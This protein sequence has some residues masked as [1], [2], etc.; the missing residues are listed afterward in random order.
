MNNYMAPYIALEGNIGSG[1]STLLRT[2]ASR[3]SDGTVHV[4]QE[5]VDEWESSKLLQAFYMDPLKNAAYFQMYVHT[6]RVRQVIQSSSTN[7]KFMVAERS[8]LSS[9]D[10]FGQEM[11]DM[12]YMGD[13]AWTAYTAVADL[14]NDL[15]HS[16]GNAVNPAGVIYLRC[17][18]EVCM[19]RVIKRS[20]ETE[21][22]GV[23]LDYLRRI[24]ARYETW[25]QHLSAI[26][27]P[28]LVLDGDVQGAQAVEQHASAL[29]EWLD[30]HFDSSN[31]VGSL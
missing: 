10:V 28:V 7:A 22:T 15:C 8:L 21:V 25:V 3:Y 14:L 29:S 20:R 4:L 5:P 19:Q 23:T 2:L 18:P 12:G 16:S 26:D 13:H 11:R 6:T 9:V 17:S 1:K 27:T 30:K 24:H 31:S